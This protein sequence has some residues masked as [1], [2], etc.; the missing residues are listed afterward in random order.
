MN[1]AV[2]TIWVITFSFHEEVPHR[3]LL[4]RFG[5]RYLKTCSR[6]GPTA[7]TIIEGMMKMKIGKTSFTPTATPTRTV[8]HC[9]EQYG[10]EHVQAF[11]VS[12]ERRD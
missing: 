8:D 10:V 7:T 11:P 4:N 6:P 12:H 5:N 1:I 3:H 2:E 9:A